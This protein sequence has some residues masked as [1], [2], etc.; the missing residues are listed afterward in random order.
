MD[1]DFEERLDTRDILKIN[2]LAAYRMLS[3]IELTP[4]IPMNIK[5]GI[6]TF[7]AN[8]YYFAGEHAAT[9]G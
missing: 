5:A 3:D 2:L 4:G 1:R 6:S 8:R 9:K 7:L